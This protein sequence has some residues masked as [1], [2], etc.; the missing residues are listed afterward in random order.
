MVCLPQSTTAI[1][2][3]SI[4][5]TGATRYYEYG[6]YDSE[7]KGLVKRQTVPDVV[8]GK[9]GRPTADSMNS[10]LS[11]VSKKAGHGG[12][13]EG[14]YVQSDSFDKMVGFTE[15]RM[16][17]NADPKREPYGITDNNC[18]TFMKQTLEAGGVDT[19]WM[20]DPR[21]NSYIKELQ[22]DFPR[23]QQSGAK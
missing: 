15:G 2:A 11:A 19:P 17:G 13:V 4:H 6:R 23:V 20:I 7:G 9:D 14:A 5:V 16:A 3:Q 21:P 12:R 22:S 1:H 8:M 18:G 10:L